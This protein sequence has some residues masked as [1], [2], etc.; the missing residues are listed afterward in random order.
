[1]TDPARIRRA[2]GFD[3]DAVADRSDPE[4]RTHR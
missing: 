3:L 2:A 1:M 4:W